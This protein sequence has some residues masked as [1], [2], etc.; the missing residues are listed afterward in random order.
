MNMDFFKHS[1]PQVFEYKRA[2]GR[3][4]G[5]M[6]GST[7]MNV[8]SSLFQIGLFDEDIHQTSLNDEGLT[9]EQ[10]Q[11]ARIHEFT[12]DY[13]GYFTIAIGIHNLLVR[14]HGDLNFSLFAYSDQELNP[15]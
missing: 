2:G 6:I 10:K 8:Y 11:K 9:E 5:R 14:T 15:I 13:V 1:N 12:K 7:Y 4:V 3:Y